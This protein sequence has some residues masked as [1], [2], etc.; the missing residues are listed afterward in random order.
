MTIYQ[1]DAV[2]MMA[3][4]F[5]LVSLALYYWVSVW[6]L[7]VPTFVG[8]NLLQYGITK[9]CP[10]AYIFGLLGLPDATAPSKGTYV[11]APK[12]AE[13]SKAQEMV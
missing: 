10:A 5:I 3:G 11:G 8:A 1:Q 13:E 7:I 9:F 12:I 6:F 4:T 2:H